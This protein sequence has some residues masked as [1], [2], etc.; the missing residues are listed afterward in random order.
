MKCVICKSP[1]IVEKEVDEEIRVDSDIAI[2]SIKTKV[3]NN[4]GE[5]YYDRKTMAQL[6]EVKD[7]LKK[8]KLDMQVIGR[9]LRISKAA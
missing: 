6:E 4:C 9:V 1:D 7:K 2:Y 8:K 3:C 5:R